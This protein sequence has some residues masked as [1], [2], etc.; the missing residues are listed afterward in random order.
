MPG[1]LKFCVGRNYTL[2]S[3]QPTQNFSSPGIVYDTLENKYL[4]KYQLVIGGHEIRLDIV[5]NEIKS[6]WSW[7]EKYT[8][9][10]PSYIKDYIWGSP[11]IM[12]SEFKKT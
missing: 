1:E 11:M 10:E 4:Y 5:Y 3:N 6:F 9:I 7:L 12:Y 8:V 2:L